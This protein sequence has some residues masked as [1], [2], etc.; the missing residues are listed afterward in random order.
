VIPMRMFNMFSKCFL[1]GPQCGGIHYY[2]PTRIEC[3]QGVLLSTVQHDG[4]KV[5]HK[6]H[7]Q[8]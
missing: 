2:I 4:A 3:T 6:C 8:T 5:M 1:S 7:N